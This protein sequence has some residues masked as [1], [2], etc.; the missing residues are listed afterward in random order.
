MVICLVWKSIG[1]FSMGKFIF[2][3]GVSP[4]SIFPKPKL[5]DKGKSPHAIYSSTASHLPI[6]R[7]PLT[8]ATSLA[9]SSVHSN[10]DSVAQS[11]AF[12]YEWSANIPLPH[13]GLGQ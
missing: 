6:E 8:K 5:D 10:D 4:S 13:P 2:D 7:V 12:I 1:N 9:S 11:R 3:T